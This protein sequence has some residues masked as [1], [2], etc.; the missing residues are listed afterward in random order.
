ML[1]QDAASSTVLMMVFILLVLVA[2]RT[3]LLTELS[4]SLLQPFALTNNIISCLCGVHLHYKSG[5]QYGN[6]SRACCRQQD[7]NWGQGGKR[8][9]QETLVAPLCSPEPTPRWNIF[10][11][12]AIYYH[13]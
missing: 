1:C 8:T 11:R 10:V 5:V 13:T 7:C 12:S 4:K 3:S 2:L 6:Q 9:V